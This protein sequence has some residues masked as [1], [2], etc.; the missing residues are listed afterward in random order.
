MEWR[1]VHR[2]SQ[3]QRQ[4]AGKS[5]LLIY[6]QHII[7]EAPPLSCYLSILPCV[8][9][10]EFV[11]LLAERGSWSLAVGGVVQQPRNKHTGKTSSSY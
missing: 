11:C 2:R 9:I 3:S 6:S 1:V 8:V 4:H 10:E 5:A 7:L